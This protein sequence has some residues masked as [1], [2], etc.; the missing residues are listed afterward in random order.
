MADQEVQTDAELTATRAIFYAAFEAY[1]KGRGWDLGDDGNPSEALSAEQL[2]EARAAVA[3][4]GRTW[5]VGVEEGAMDRLQAQADE[6]LR[7]DSGFGAQSR[8]AFVTIGVRK[9][10]EPVQAR[11]EAARSFAFQILDAA[12]GAEHDGLTYA[13]AQDK[14]GLKPIQ[15]GQEFREYR[16]AARAADRADMEASQTLDGARKTQHAIR[17]TG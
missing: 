9:G 8:R 3:D 2:E 12:A 10:D 11:P 7:V 6:G 5:A 16:E 4:V 13:W 1:C 17:P 14:L 15:A